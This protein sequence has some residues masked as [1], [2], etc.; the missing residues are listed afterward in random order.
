MS[1]LVLFQRFGTDLQKAAGLIGQ[2]AERLNAVYALQVK[3]ETF[4]DLE[5]LARKL[6]FYEYTQETYHDRM[7]TQNGISTDLLKSFLEPIMRVNYLQNSDMQALAGSAGT[8]GF[9]YSFGSVKEGSVKLVEKALDAAKADIHLGTKVIE[10]KKNGKKF[11]I[12]TEQCKKKKCHTENHNV[13]AVIIATPLELSDIQ[14]KSVPISECALHKR[15]FR[16]THVTIVT[17]GNLSL[18]ILIHQN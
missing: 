9:V 8:A 4:E 17:G 15:K 6:G 14:F 5:S 2:V 12:K 13:D 1:S 16:E 11:K 18:W 3:N 7:I 10:I